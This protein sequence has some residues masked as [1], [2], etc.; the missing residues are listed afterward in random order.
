MPDAT[1]A[2][3]ESQTPAAAEEAVETQEV[4]STEEE[5]Q[6]E[7]PEATE[8]ADDQ[9]PAETEAAAD[10]GDSGADEAVEEKP[11]EVA[12][13]AEVKPLP[14]E[15]IERAK[16]VG[17]SEQELKQYSD[18]TKLLLDVQRVEDMAI[19]RLQALEAAK[20]QETPKQEAQ[21]EDDFKIDLD[22]K[23]YDPKIVNALK[24]LKES[25]EKKLERRIA[26][27]EQ[28]AQGL[29]SYVHEQQMKAATERL[30]GL[31]NGLGEETKQLFGKGAMDSVTP[32]ERDNRW[33]VVQQMAAIEEGYSKLGLKLP[34]EKEL[35]R[36]AVEAV[37]GEDIKKSARKEISQQLTKQKSKLMQRPAAKRTGANPGLSPELVAQRNVEAKMRALGI[38]PM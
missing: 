18:G 32:A 7:T 20:T 15:V 26:Q 33:K 30:D 4:E 3:V 8:P 38:D 19:R 27:Y 35:H 13:Q 14:P 29:V 17:F 9:I 5:V 1:E 25:F 36:R 6:Q 24:G 28:Q 11:A 34:A 10:E 2:A 22:E 31:F 12:P 23:E 16:Q 21:A 37:F